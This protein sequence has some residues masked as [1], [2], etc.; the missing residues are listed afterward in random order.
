MGKKRRLS[1]TADIPISNQ[2]TKMYK[3]SMYK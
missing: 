2:Q 1:A 3:K